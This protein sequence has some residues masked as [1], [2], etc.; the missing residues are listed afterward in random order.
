[1]RTACR[2]SP[3]YVRSASHE[4]G[5]FMITLRKAG[6]G[7]AALVGMAVASP[8]LAD[9]ATMAFQ[10]NVDKAIATLNQMQAL[11]EQIDKRHRDQAAA[12]ASVGTPGA[13]VANASAKTYT[14]VLRGAM[15]P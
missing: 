3:E 8:V 9:E 4:G 14:V 15:C 12:A 5:F 6:I 7:L 2:L 10:A 13:P 1:M 11:F